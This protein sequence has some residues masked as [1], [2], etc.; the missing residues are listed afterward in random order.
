MIASLQMR[1]TEIFVFIAVQVLSYL[2]VKSCTQKEKRI[3][4]VRN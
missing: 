1:N 2:A 3:E 4:I